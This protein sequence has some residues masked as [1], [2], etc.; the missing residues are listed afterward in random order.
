MPGLQAWLVPAGAPE[1]SRQH[2]RSPPTTGSPPPA[3][4]P[5]LSGCPRT[6]VQCRFARAF[7]TKAWRST[8][9]LKS[10][11][12]P[13]AGRHAYSARPGFAAYA[14]RRVSAPT[15]SPMRRWGPAARPR[16]RGHCGR[17]GLNA[18]PAYPGPD[19][20]TSCGTIT[21]IELREG[22]PFRPLMAVP[23]G[24]RR[25]FLVG[26]AHLR[27]DLARSPAIFPLLAL[28]PRRARGIV[29]PPAQPPSI[30]SVEGEN[31]S[32]AVYG[33]TWCAT[34]VGPTSLS[35]RRRR[36]DARAQCHDALIAH[37]LLFTIRFP[38][39]ASRVWRGAVRRGLEADR[40]T[41][42]ALARAQPRARHPLA[43]GSDTP[44]RPKL[45][46]KRWRRTITVRQRVMEKGVLKG[47]DLE[48]VARS[49]GD[50]EFGV[51]G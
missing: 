33:L 19:G 18:E 48:A 40:R 46:K 22:R 42:R 28:G 31:P 12:T 38:S 17:H 36:R 32:I 13:P 34:S 15:G 25:R 10:G 23:W 51:P 39:N 4:W 45:A 35:R 6:R 27:M 5:A 11:L 26:V 47:K 2:V 21:G 50:D 8:Q 30:M 24:K 44:R 41:V 1:R 20:Q 3:G 14:I 43:P 29:L 49:T 16:H 7:L 37:N 9:I